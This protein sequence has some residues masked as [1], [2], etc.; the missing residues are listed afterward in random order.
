M[1]VI[2]K[3]MLMLKKTVKNTFHHEDGTVSADSFRKGLTDIEMEDL[4]NEVVL[5]L[6]ESLQEGINREI[7]VERLEELFE[8]YGVSRNNEQTSDSDKSMLS[9]IIR[10]D[11][12]IEGLGEF[13]DGFP[14]NSM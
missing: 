11:S 13:C 8:C 9:V 3:H 1:E 4:G 14:F 7:R 10:N 6:F 2:A 5:Q 12:S